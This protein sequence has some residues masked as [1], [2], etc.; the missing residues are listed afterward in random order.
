M[1]Y[2][3]HEPSTWGSLEL[4]VRRDVVGAG[5]GQA[6]V[7]WLNASVQRRSEF[8]LHSALGKDSDKDNGARDTWVVTGGP[9]AHPEAGCAW[10]RWWAVN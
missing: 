1:L 4:T 10:G 9:W 7:A 3:V 5:L 2:R 6:L 8:E